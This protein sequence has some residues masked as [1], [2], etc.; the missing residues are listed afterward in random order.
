MTTTFYSR[1]QWGAKRL[2]RLGHVVK[3]HQFRRLVG[4]HTVSVVKD[5][6]GD[7]FVRGDVDDIFRFM[8]NLQTV[9]PDLGLDVPYS[10]VVFPGADEDDAIVCVGRGETRTGAHT[11]GYNSTA[12]GVAVAGNTSEE[13]ITRGMERAIL[14]I[15]GKLSAEDLRATIGHSDTKAT[16]CPGDSYRD[17]LPRLQPEYFPGREASL[18]PKDEEMFIT[19]DSKLKVYRVHIAGV[20][21]ATIDEPG[22]WFEV[23][24]EGRKTGIYSSAWMDVLLWKIAVEE[25]ERAELAAA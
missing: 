8:R 21:Y 7:G 15:G 18:T 9:R 22:H 24:T 14:E 23:I 4:H 25:A 1:K 10:F 16:E 12:W 3:K 2:P 20:G 13:P 6:D 17:A 5:W 11:A 19:Y